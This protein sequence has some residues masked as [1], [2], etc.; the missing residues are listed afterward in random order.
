MNS[1]IKQLDTE[2]WEAWI[3]FDHFDPKNFGIL[4][5]MGEAPIAFKSNLP[6]ISKSDKS[7]DEG[8]LVLELPAIKGESRT[9]I[10]EVLFS[11]SIGQMQQ[12]HTIMIY[13]GDD[14]LIE[15]SDIEVLV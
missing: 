3:E 11:E 9:R 7:P 8:I 10:K 6:C 14:L 4:Y 1:T 12:Y 15:I 5:V 13:R 2:L